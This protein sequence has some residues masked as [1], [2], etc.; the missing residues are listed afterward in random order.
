MSLI[1]SIP[2]PLKFLAVGGT[3]ATVHFVSVIL[4]VEY[5]CLP[6]LV[7]NIGAFLIAFLVSFSG[8]R[9]L[10]FHD[11]QTPLFQGL[12]RFFLIALSSFIVNECLLAIAIE[13]FKIPYMLALACVLLIVA[14]G[15]YFSSKHWAF[16]V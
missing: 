14:I 7:A 9:F 4:F 5:A 6:A 3:A 15:T 16:K 12:K 11:S 8:Q 13:I 10:T 1:K 2:R